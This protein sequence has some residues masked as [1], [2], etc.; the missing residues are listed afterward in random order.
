MAD[1]RRIK[2]KHGDSE[3]EADV[4]ADK[5]QPMYD[6][7]LATLEKRNQAPPAPF[8]AGKNNPDAKPNPLAQ[9][10]EDQADKQL[11]TRL[12]DLRA[13]GIV[14]LRVLP[15]G[16]TK[17]ADAFLLLLYGYRRIN[18]QEDVL[19]THLLRA[20]EL[21]GLAAYRPAHALAPHEHLIIRG[22]HK[23]GSTYSLN[24]QGIIKV[25]EIAARIFE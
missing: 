21:S 17:E 4:P 14:T 15:K 3:F 7:F 11:L 10:L 13:D 5:V 2:I 24:N 9:P 6:Q 20:A 19:A 16:D 8:N 22:G 18:E 12:F 25:Q 1:I 23:K